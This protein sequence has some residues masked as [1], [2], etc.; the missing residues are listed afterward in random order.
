MQNVGT[1]NSDLAIIFLMCLIFPIVFYFIGAMFQNMS[2]EQLQDNPKQ[3]NPTTPRQTPTSVNISVSIPN[4]FKGSS[5]TGK[6]R[7][8]TKQSTKP[9]K[10]KRSPDNPKPLTDEAVVSDVVSGLCHMGYKKGEATKIV[11][12][13]SDKKEYNS[14][15]S[16][17]KD[18]FMCIS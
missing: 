16:L 5:S 2:S 9:K 11:K 12:S 13:I 17:L 6:S 18:C 4:L 3:E 14:A 10:K 8:K 7:K 1:W 15:E